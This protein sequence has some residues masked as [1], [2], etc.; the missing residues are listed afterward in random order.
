MSAGH[1]SNPRAGAFGAAAAEYE[2]GRP[3]YPPAAVDWLV[4]AGASRVLDLGAG[5][6]K[7]TRLLADRGLEVVAVEPLAEMREQL[8]RVL[9]G[10]RVMAGA[11]ERI[12]ADDHSFDAVLVAQAWHW[13]DAR[14][15]VPEVARVLRPGGWL[16]LAWNIRDQRQ[17]WVGAL[18]RILYRHGDRDNEHSVPT[19]GPPF[20]QIQRLDLEWSQHLTPDVLIDLVASRSYV[21]TLPEAQ[22]AAVIAEVRELVSSHPAT[23]GRLE[24][25]LPYVTRCSRTQLAQDGE[26]PGA[27]S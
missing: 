25:V 26:G 27:R 20:G 11:A 2:R 17:D 14:L 4:P 23:A 7:L 8:S 15:A 12:P 21:I 6:G 9:P 13:V 24:I 22:R 1:K 5:T 18:G 16:G 19:I 10:V 3:S